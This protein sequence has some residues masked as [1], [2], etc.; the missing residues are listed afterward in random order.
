MRSESAVERSLRLQRMIDELQ[1]EMN[2]IDKD[3][4]ESQDKV[5]KDIHDVHGASLQTPSTSQIDIPVETPVYKDNTGL[6]SMRTAL[7]PVPFELHKIDDPQ[8][9]LNQEHEHVYDHNWS[10]S[11]QDWGPGWFWDAGLNE[12]LLMNPVFGMKAKV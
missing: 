6:E 9:T 11:F 5:L 2:L 4:E 3:C 8:G 10:T 1:V 7:E 12:G